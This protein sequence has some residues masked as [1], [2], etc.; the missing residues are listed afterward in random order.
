MLLLILSVHPEHLLQPSCRRPLYSL[1]FVSSVAERRILWCWIDC[2][3]WITAHNFITWDVIF[4]WGIAVPHSFHH[5]IKFSALHYLFSRSVGSHNNALYSCT[6]LYSFPIFLQA[7][8]CVLS[9]KTNFHRTRIVPAL[10]PQ[11]SAKADAILRTLP[12]VFSVSATS[13]ISS[14]SYN[15]AI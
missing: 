6:L 11:S 2:R 7:Y 10:R 4:F 5:F 8:S 1:S 9:P 12:A 14:T 3:Y 15:T 13:S